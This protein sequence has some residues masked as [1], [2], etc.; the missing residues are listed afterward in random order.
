MRSLTEEIN[1]HSEVATMYKVQSTNYDIY[2]VIQNAKLIKFP[3]VV[4][5]SFTHTWSICSSQSLEFTCKYNL[6]SSM[7]NWFGK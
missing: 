5:V 3:C 1:S 2:K 7:L 4:Y 6:L